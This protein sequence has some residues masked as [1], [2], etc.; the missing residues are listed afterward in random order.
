MNIEKLPN[1]E[2]KTVLFRMAIIENDAALEN[3]V[4]ETLN[5]RL[6]VTGIMPE[7]TSENDWCAGLLTSLAWDAVQGY[8]VFEDTADYLSRAS[9]A[10]GNQRLH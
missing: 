6:F 2:N 5:G 3:P 4:F 10:W 1:F 7:G 9:Q 8:T